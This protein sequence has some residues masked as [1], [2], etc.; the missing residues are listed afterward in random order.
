M[1][2]R[3]KAVQVLGSASVGVWLARASLAIDSS[4]AAR[5]LGAAKDESTPTLAPGS[6]TSP[7]RISLIDA[8]K[9]RSE[10]LE[11]KFEARTLKRDWTM[12]YRLF[13]PQATG[14]MP[15]VLYLHGS[16][17]QGDDNFKQ[18]GLGN[19][20]G[21]RVW[22][23]PENQRKFPCY[24][25]VPQSNR[26]WVRYDPA[27][28]DKEVYEMVPGLGQGTGM[29]LEVVEAL[30]REFSIDERRIYVTGQSMGG[31][32]TWNIITNRPKFFAAAAICCGSRSTED[33]TGSIETPVWNF[34][35]EAD[36][37]VP[38]SLSRERIAARRKAGGSAFYTE[39]SGVDHNVWEWAFTE[40]ELV[41]W[42][43][44]QR[45][46]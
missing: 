34:H 43:F 27:K 3:R 21:T 29:A 23:L 33:G 38:V 39:Y 24:V 10:G 20:F 28:L 46:E 6:P 37:T 40:P 45:R 13:R 9:K 25:V 35:G 12:P 11:K 30:V 15:L 42:L 4:P 19:I 5:I 7:E 26:G 17:G 1:I 14:K 16:G 44:S 8:F 22:L 31:A 32:G 18:L 41:K 36:Q 2:T